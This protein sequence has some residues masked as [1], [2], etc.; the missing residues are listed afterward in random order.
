[1]YLGLV[2]AGVLLAP[3]AVG[4]IQLFAPVPLDKSPAVLEDRSRALV[5]RFTQGEEP[6]DAAFGFDVDE[7]YFSHVR[8][9]DA[10]ST[11]WDSLPGGVPSVV[12]VWYRQSLHPLVTTNPMGEVYWDNPPLAELA[13]NAGVRLDMRG[14]LLS[15]Y[16]VPPQLEEAKGPFP[17]P[18]WSP[19][20]VEA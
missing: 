19:L 20:F 10:S 18:D 8:E 7:S 9:T 14:R 1:L 6:T 17:R 12:G 13:G 15:F 3:L 5:Q 16:S 11:R 2:V 4:P